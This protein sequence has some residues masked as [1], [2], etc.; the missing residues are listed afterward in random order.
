[1][2]STIL[3]TTL[4]LLLFGTTFGNNISTNISWIN[5]DNPPDFGRSP[6]EPTTSDLV[7]F[8]IPT[9]VYINS[10]TAEQALGGVPTLSVDPVD[11]IVEL[12]FDPPAPGGDPPSVHNQVCGLEGYFGPLEEGAWIFF[13]HFPGSI[14]LD[15]FNITTAPVT[16][17]IS[18][19][20]ETEDDE[21]ISDVILTFSNGGGSTTT[22]SAGFY[23]RSVP[24]GWSGTVTPSKSDYDFQP[25]S[26]S[27]DNVTSNKSNQNYTGSTETTP[28]PPTTD[29]YFTEQFTSGE[30]AFDLSNKSITFT[31][32]MDG[33]Y[34]SAYLEEI[35]ELPTNPAGGEQLALGDDNFHSVSLGE[36]ATVFIYGSSFSSFYV[37]SNGYIT[38]TE[39][40]NDYSDSFIDHFRTRR[41]SGL[42]NDFNP[43]AGGQIS[44][45]Q[46]AD[47]V[48][49]TWENIP[50]YSG[51]NS[52]TFQIEMFFDGRICL[53]WLGV[54]ADTGIVGLSEGLGVPEGF[55]ETDLSEIESPSEPPPLE[56]D[57]VA[58]QF[59]SAGDAFDLSNKSI[60]LTPET[61]GAEYHVYLYDITE[62]PTNPTGS[63]GLSLGDDDYES[64]NLDGEATVSI[65]GN[66]F[67]SF[68]V[69]SNGYITFVEGDNDYSDT[70]FDHFEVLRIS[71]L[72]TDLNP[73][74]GGQVSWKQLEDR[75]V[76]T[77]ENVPEYSG[78]NPNT[79]QIEMFFDGRIRLSWLGI[80]ADSG[81]VGLSAGLGVPDDFEETDL[82]E[83]NSEPVP[84]PES[85]TILEY[86]AEQFSAG[87]DAFDLS[88]KSIMFTPTIDNAAYSVYLQAI[89][90]L[91]TNPTDGTNLSLG[92]DDFKFAK[93]NG[94]AHVSIYGNTFTGFYIGSN[95]YV[96]FTDGDNDHSENMTD[97]FAMARISAL[98]NDLNPSA[99]GQVSWK[100]LADRAVVT[101]ENVPEYGGNNSNTFQ[102]EMYFDG[103][104][105]IS[106]LEVESVTGLVGLSDGLGVPVD[107]TETDLSEINTQST[108]PTI[109]AHIAE[110]FTSEDDAFDLSN[111]SIL[112]TPTSDGTSYSAYINDITQLPTDPA[113]SSGFVLGD[114]DYQHIILN[115]DATVSIYGNNFGDFYVGSNGY[116]TF[117]EGENE[118]SDTLPNHFNALRISALFEDLDPSNSGAVSWKQFT[119][120]A[121]VT[122]ENVP[123]YGK[124]NPNTFQIEMYFDGRIRLSWLVV[125]SI[126]GIVGLSAGLGVPEDFEET[127]LSEI[128][129][130]PLPP[131]PPTTLEYTAEQF[132]LPLND[133]FDLSNKSIIFTPTSDGVSYGAYLDE[134]T[135]LPT[136]PEGGTQLSLRDDD[137]EHVDLDGGAT[138]SIYGSSFGGF[139]V[140]SNG[141]ITFTEGDNDF[142]GTLADH[143]DT[144]RI[145]ALFEDFDPPAGGQISWK[146]LADRAVVTW[147]NVYEYERNHPN[148]FQVEMYFDGRIQISW[149]MIA[150]NNGIVGL[151]DGLGVPVGFEETDFSEVQMLP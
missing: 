19:Y 62:L 3:G 63:T 15:S 33:A 119:D 58:E 2:R 44:W 47:R 55:Q 117:T 36:G 99:G 21:G 70:L 100:Q 57:Y 4:V 74:A 125:E 52:S 140:G 149:L 142:S 104:I 16:P 97:H 29:N 75:A 83:I 88:N 17:I 89:T 86:I 65:Y 93:L 109:L 126:S 131:S 138:V 73:S 56:L 69:G 106:W 132:F 79:F 26:R 23:T 136:N 148:T 135:S 85:P 51:T 92:D 112:L 32:E 90:Q 11:R 134:I 46:L 8:T 34:Y 118:Y 25:T 31:P 7:Y 121:V 35:T 77:W 76:V 139:Y 27:Y 22:N 98:F 41:I 39:G 137:S 111:K 68:Y 67:T 133:G 107:F 143:F 82:S 81:I 38:F 78:N 103:K 30:D 123:K 48:V 59:S 43:T 130:L 37:G 60:M 14:Y 72:F 80:E 110:Q 141:Y 105:Q 64:I 50:E 13:S 49:V 108:P 96:T 122:W 124:N 87:D 5:G 128:D 6:D 24:N 144:L 101:W 129:K 151:S 66:G 45:K 113:G 1:M 145:S 18:G 115:N 71:A 94:E 42:Y 20:V 54:D 127:D 114:D 150:V 146:Q 84:P 120:R 12:F 9:S 116:I 40:D 147:M 10:W 53:S 91:P 95:G 28:P 102:I 61:D